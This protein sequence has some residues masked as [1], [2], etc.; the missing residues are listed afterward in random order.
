L[1]DGDIIEAAT[2]MAHY[3]EQPDAAK[4]R[5]H[6]RTLLVSGEVAAFGHI[7]MTRRF[8]ILLKTPGNEQKVVCEFSVPQ[9]YTAIYTTKAGSE[10]VGSAGKSEVL[11]AR[12]GQTVVIRGR[13]K[14]LRGGMVTLSQCELK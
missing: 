8:T 2:L 10:L 7:M 6:Q 9:S 12:L 11:L 3:Q 5:Y 4:S 1:K 14:G 13:C